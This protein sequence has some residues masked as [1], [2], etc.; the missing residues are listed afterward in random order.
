M[1]S[2][3]K[4]VGEFEEAVAAFAGSKYGVA[5][6][7][8]TN[9]LF[10]C[11]KYLKIDSVILPSRTYPSVPCSVIH[12]GG[13]V[14][15]EDFEW[16]SQRFYRLTPYPIYDAA[17]LFCQNMYQAVHVPLCGGDKEIYPNAFVCL[18]FSSTKQINIGKGGM[19]LTDDENAVRWFKQARYCG[20]HEVPMNGDHF[21]MLG[22]NMYMTPEQAARGL[23]LMTTRDLSSP[24]APMPNY[25]DLSQFP[26]YANLT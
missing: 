5:V 6:D 7:S 18:S 13:T 14:Q 26:I 3:Y 4:I 2:P 1:S 17:H 12:A 9:A 25:P 15:F 22:W 19:I 24:P 8:C 10:L 20:R 11:A 21:D 23:L 16:R